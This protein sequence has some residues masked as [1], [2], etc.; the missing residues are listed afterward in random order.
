MEGSNCF[1][2][3]AQHCRIPPFSSLIIKVK[4]KH[5]SNKAAL[6]NGTARL[7]PLFSCISSLSVPPAMYTIRNNVSQIHAINLS[8]RFKY[9]KS[10]CKVTEFEHLT[11]PFK[12]MDLPVSFSMTTQSTIPVQQVIE[13]ALK[14]SS[15]ESPVAFSDADRLLR[16]L[17]TD[18]PNVLPSPSRPLGRTSLLEQSIKLIQ[19]TFR[20]T[21]SPTLENCKLSRKS[22]G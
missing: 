4:A 15:S 21:K 17:F 22:K 2:T 7:D 14:T 1:F 8:N 6:I 16:N 20:L 10:G 19:L 3:A 11:L 18:F 12:T 13:N 5:P 9:I